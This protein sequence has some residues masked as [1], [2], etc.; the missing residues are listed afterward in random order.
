M[1]TVEYLDGIVKLGLGPGFGDERLRLGPV[2]IFSDGSI[3]AGT[4]ALKEPYLGNLREQGILIWSR[5]ELEEMVLKAYESD[6]QLAIHAIGDRAVEL[7]LDCFERANEKE[8][9]TLRHRIEHCEMLSPEQIRRMKEMSIIASMQPNFVGQWGL[10]GGMYEVR[11]GKERTAEMN[12]FAL[13]K[14]AGVKLAFGSDCMPF[15]PLYGVHWA[16]NAPFPSQ[17]ISPEDALKAYTIG[18]AYASFEEGYKGT[19]EEGKL[20]DLVVLD[21]NPFTGPSGIKDM[22]IQLTIF[23]GK[24]VYERA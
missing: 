6:V 17:K 2:K 23:D 12:P 11:L 21:G 7:V 16:V 22:A 1:P 3:G 13:L 8:K 14:K 20:A 9:K 4:A 19:I 10:P 24:V 15:G 18:G 5:E